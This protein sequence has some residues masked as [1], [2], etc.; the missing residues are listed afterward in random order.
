[1]AVSSS[2]SSSSSSSTAARQRRKCPS[3]LRSTAQHFTASVLGKHDYSER[4]P[5]PFLEERQYLGTHQR[6]K[7][8]VFVYVQQAL[9]CNAKQSPPCHYTHH[10]AMFRCSV[11]LSPNARRE[12]LEDG[13]WE[14]TVPWGWDGLRSYCTF[15]HTCLLSTYMIWIYGTHGYHQDNG[16]HGHTQDGRL[17]QSKCRARTR[18]PLPKLWFRGRKPQNAKPARPRA[19]TVTRCIHYSADYLPGYVRYWAAAPERERKVR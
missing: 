19:P 2:S 1:M 9:T 10:T 11:G 3:Q 4:S 7:C 8:R 16:Y 14:G 12:P 5:G 17:A 18:E 15:T 13:S 6:G